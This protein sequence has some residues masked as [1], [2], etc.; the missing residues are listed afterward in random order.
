MKKTEIINFIKKNKDRLPLSYSS[1]VFKDFNETKIRH[2]IIYSE[3]YKESDYGLS[4][5]Y[6]D[7]TRF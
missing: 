3:K 6:K 4:K 1:I 7:I 2:K 5:F